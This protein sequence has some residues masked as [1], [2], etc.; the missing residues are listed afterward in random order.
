MNSNRQSQRGNM[1]APKSSGGFEKHPEGAYAIVCTRIIDMGSVFNPAKNKDDHKLMI[2]FESSELMTNVDNNGK[3]FMVFGN[4]NFTMFQNSHLCKFVEA[5]KGKAFATQ[6]E[7]D[8][9][10]LSKLLAQPAFANIVYNGD[11]VNIQSIMPVPK[12][13]DSPRPV[14]ELL[15]FDMA[16]QDKAV[17]DKLSEK[18]Q[19]RLKKAKEFGSVFSDEP[20]AGHPATEPDDDGIPFK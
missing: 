18:M 12:G 17:F 11:Y 6:E 20:P 14:G 2:G 3:P 5:W 1:K 15:I 7:A 9:F 10:D 16:T 8:V 4:F 13:M 19:E